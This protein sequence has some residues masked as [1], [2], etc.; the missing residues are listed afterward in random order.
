[1]MSRCVVYQQS[2]ADC[3][4]RGD[5]PATRALPPTGDVSKR[6][7]TNNAHS[8]LTKSRRQLTYNTEIL[9][10]EITFCGPQ[11]DVKAKF[12]IKHFLLFKCLLVHFIT[13]K[14]KVAVQLRYGIIR[15]YIRG[16]VQKQV[17][18]IITTTVLEFTGTIL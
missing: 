18:A 1:M 13:Y 16:Y 15:T 8:K 5:N 10:N 11:Y 17:T 4:Q 6:E 2:E 12:T 14:K 7:I 3:L 9:N